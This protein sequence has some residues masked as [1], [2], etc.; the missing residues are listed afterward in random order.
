VGV[1]LYGHETHE[2]WNAFFKEA[3]SD[4]QEFPSIERVVYFS[5]IIIITI[6]IITVGR[7]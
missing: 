7:C 5:V 1:C 4:P 6:I 2:A 3:C